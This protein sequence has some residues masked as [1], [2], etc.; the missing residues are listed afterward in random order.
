MRKNLSLILVM[1]ILTISCKDGKEQDEVEFWEFPAQIDLENIKKRGTIRAIV[2]NS[3]T[4]YYIY[5]GRRMGYEY[6]MLR[7]LS[8]RLD[9]Q[10]RLVITDDIE[11]AF[12]FLNQGNADIIA[13]NLEVS[14]VRKQYANFTNSTNNLSTVLV[15]RTGGE[16][17]ADLSE[18]D[19]K[20]IHIRSSSI[21]KEQLESLQDSLNLKLYV[22]EENETLENLVSRVA[23]G[24]IDYTIVDNDIALVNATYY[25]NIDVNLQISEPSAVGWAVRKNAPD[26]LKEINNW[27]EEAKESAYFAIL[28][29]KYFTNKKNSYFRNTSAF[30]SISGDRISIYDDIIQKGANELG[31]DWRLLAALVYKE[32]RFDNTA[33][34]YAGAQGLLQLMPVTLERFDVSNANDP[35]Q[36]LM[37]GV[38]FLKYLDKFWRERIPESNE[39]IKFILASYNVGHGHVEDAWR[40]TLKFGKDTKLWANVAYFLERKSQ[41]E[42]YRDPVVK[43]GY[44]KGHVTVAYVRDVISLY[45]SYRVLVQP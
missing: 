40:L 44:A 4:S 6:E 28:Y 18:L 41:P 19:N 10:L 21:Y 3:S 26:L 42:F 43:S 32:S 27:I 15:Q 33:I 35:S 8:N 37:A 29:G 36:S 31:W 39:R 23:S 13:M 5:R 17:L 34:S 20:T 22:L 45:E 16:I 1:V 7:D 14:E 2:D 9:V 30:S 25:E 38:Q 12:K 24:E 11:E